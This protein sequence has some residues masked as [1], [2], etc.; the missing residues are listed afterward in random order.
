MKGNRTLKLRDE[1]RLGAA[2][3]IG[4]RLDDNR[5]SPAALAPAPNA[6]EIIEETYKRAPTC[7]D[8]FHGILLPMAYRIG[9]PTEE[10][11]VTCP[12]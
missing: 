11:Q 1:E 4:A 8:R 5:T 12:C 9:H 7:T 10:E 6:A 2:S 3:T